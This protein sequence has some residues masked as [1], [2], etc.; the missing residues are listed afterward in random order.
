[1]SAS[2]EGDS[3]AHSASDSA[4]AAET[5]PAGSP[6]ADTAEHSPVP[7]EHSAVAS[8]TASPSLVSANGSD[9]ACSDECNKRKD[10]PTGYAA[11]DDDDDD[12]GNANKATDD[13]DDDDAAHTTVVHVTPTPYRPTS[14][15]QRV[16]EPQPV[17][18]PVFVR[19]PTPTAAHVAE[20]EAEVEANATTTAEVGDDGAVSYM[21]RVGVP[22][23]I[24][25]H[26]LIA[27]YAAEC[28][29]TFVFT[30]TFA[31]VAMNNP[32]AAGKPDTNI[33]ALP[34][35]FAFMALVFT[36]GY[37]S[38]GH[39]NP[40]VTAA[41]LIIE[42]DV[43]HLG[44]MLCQC[45]GALG[46]GF[47]AMMVAGD[48]DLIVPHIANNDSVAIR[49]AVF[50]E[51]IFAFALAVVVLNVAHSR[52]RD[53]FF[54]G[55][56]IGMVVLAGTA[57]VGGVS[58]GA[59]NPAVATGLQLSACFFGKCEPLAYVWLYWVAPMLGAALAAGVFS[60]LDKDGAPV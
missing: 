4:R 6:D 43:K 1:M 3:R 29:G 55:F 33:T 7:D 15:A 47:V 23:W 12:D 13:D 10:P 9:A 60:Q 25:L 35:G 56:S 21:S 24:A 49:R 18:T 36:F 20:A 37:I 54:Y 51:F 42:R 30:L 22:D 8:G 59:F 16:A 58:G 26:P 53:N 38:G 41:V 28:L 32:S 50:A 27:H 45:G 44:Y 5:S 11:T 39:F 46:A 14:L 31:L 52:Q 57:A 48:Q 17:I 19:P 40:A 34:V 2:Q